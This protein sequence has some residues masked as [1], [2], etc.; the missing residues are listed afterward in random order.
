MEPLIAVLGVL[1]L[2]GLTHGYSGNWHDDVLY[3]AQALQKIYPERFIGDMFFI[4]E[5]QD[6]YSVFGHAFA[7]LIRALGLETATVLGLLAGHLAWIATAAMLARRLIPM[8][9]HWLGLALLVIY[10]R[11][12]DGPQRSI[13]YAEA[14]LTAR[15]WAEPLVILAIALLISGRRR[16]ALA[17]LVVA[18]VIHPIMAFPGLLLAFYVLASARVSMWATLAGFTLAIVAPWI[19]PASLQGLLGLMEPDWY[20][21]VSARSPIVFVTHWGI[22]DLLE[23]AFVVIAAAGTVLIGEPRLRRIA[24]ALAAMLACGLAIAWIAVQWPVVLV[25]QMQALRVWWLAKAMGLLLGIG[26]IA[27][28]WQSGAEGRLFALAMLASFLA[29]D[30]YGVSAPIAAAALVLVRWHRLRRPSSVPLPS[31]IVW[32]LRV[33]ITLIFV[34]WAWLR[35][36][37][38]GLTIDGLIAAATHTTV[39][40]RG[41]LGG[42]SDLFQIAAIVSIAL[43][44]LVLSGQGKR[45]ATIGIAAFLSILASGAAWQTWN[46]N[47]WGTP[48]DQAPTVAP[49]LAAIARHH[50]LIYFEGG[51]VEL[52]LRLHRASYGSNQ[53]AAGIVF[54][55]EMALEARR[56]LLNITLLNA[57]DGYFARHPDHAMSRPRAATASALRHV[58]ADARLD[59]VILGLPVPGVEEHSSFPARYGSSRHH[60]YECR[61]IRALGPDPFP[62]LD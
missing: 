17:A 18:T 11:Y 22:A 25:L 13:A 44:T 7:L 39:T 26:L 1:A 33:A 15:T 5:S 45:T 50:Q 42:L 54:S 29:V 2:W 38:I 31:H 43:I 8:P 48:R 60:A 3:A 62:D 36:L 6:D 21:I 30:G 49:E 57:R 51:H 28:Q 41:W 58:C 52:W 32:G 40:W 4:G 55:R 34:E 56:R 9:F 59:L 12:Y 47:A 19:G 61:R 27:H 35:L 20:A 14:F 53:Q 46:R 16:T 23:P 37:A 10:P 24:M